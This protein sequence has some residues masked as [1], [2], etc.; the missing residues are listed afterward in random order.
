MED[1]QMHRS[2]QFVGVLLAG[3]LLLPGT[4][5]A[6]RGQGPCAEDVKKFCAGVKPRGGGIAN[7]L[8]EHEADLSSACRD[9]ISKRKEAAANFKEACGEDVQKLCASAQR[10]RALKCL[11]G[12]FDSLSPACQESVAAMKEK[13]QGRGARKQ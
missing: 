3:A 9:Q 2:L 10:G 4:A 11:D 12:K 8:G 5:S 1:N 6:E 13:S 7:C